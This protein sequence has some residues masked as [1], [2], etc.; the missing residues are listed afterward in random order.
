MLIPSLNFQSESPS[1]SKMNNLGFYLLVSLF[2]VV[3]ALMEF[4]LVLL[5]Q[6]K[7]DA[8]PGG[9]QNKI[10]K[11]LGRNGK[12]KISDIRLRNENTE[13]YY[14]NRYSTKCIFLLSQIRN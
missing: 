12:Q 7:M 14:P 9:T 3:A 4:A 1:T 6:R 5:V 11:K 2:F 10:K 13:H 8:K